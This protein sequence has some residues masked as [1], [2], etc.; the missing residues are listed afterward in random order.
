MKHLKQFENSQEQP[1]IGDYVLIL[2]DNIDSRYISP[3]T[4][5][6]KYVDFI[7]NTI[8]KIEDINI[9]SKEITVQ[10]D[11]I[12]EGIKAWFRIEKI[13]WSREFPFDKIVAFAPTEE[14][15]KLKIQSQKYNI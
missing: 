14:I 9:K 10:Y 7:N 1:K 11:N 8:G 4:N 5:L 2:L 12:P 3:G 15:L 13:E 6:S